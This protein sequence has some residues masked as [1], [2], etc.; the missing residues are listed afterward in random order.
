MRSILIDPTAQ[1]LA[2]VDT[3]GYNDYKRLI[4]QNTLTTVG[5][6][7]GNLM[8][9]DDEAL[10]RPNP[11][12]YFQIGQMDPIAGAAIIIGVDDAGETVPSF[13]PLELVQA[14]TTFPRLRFLGIESSQE[15]I[16]HPVF[17]L[18]TVFKQKAKFERLD[19]DA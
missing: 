2:E 18:M 11:G 19:L 10:M 8:I 13:L 12:P 16:D 15:E 1:L 3:K 17:G 6:G 4:G 9:C 7:Q 14:L 5:L